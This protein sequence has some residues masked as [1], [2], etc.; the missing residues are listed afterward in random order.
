MAPF[1]HLGISLAQIRSLSDREDQGLH[2]LLV[3]N[4]YSIS[5]KNTK[6]IH[7]VRE[8]SGIRPHNVI[9]NEIGTKKILRFTDENHFWEKN[10]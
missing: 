7:K 1:R 10:H 6:N 2:C 5:H 9:R 8:A 4:Y 3:V